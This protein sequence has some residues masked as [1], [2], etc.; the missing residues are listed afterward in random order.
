MKYGWESEEERLAR[1]MK[2][3]PEAKLKWLRQINEF[4]LKCSSKKDRALR[5]K[6][7]EA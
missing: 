7:R 5:W 4:I 6:L 1:F 3:S 2:I